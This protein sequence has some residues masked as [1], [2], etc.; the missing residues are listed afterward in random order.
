MIQIKTPMKTLITSSLRIQTVGTLFIDD[1]SLKLGDDIDNEQTG[2]DEEEE[3]KWKG[4]KGEN[5]E[6]EGKN[7][8]NNNNRKD[9]EEND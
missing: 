6:R 3:E 9:G 5:E 7:D 2:L 4:A 1:L 8:K